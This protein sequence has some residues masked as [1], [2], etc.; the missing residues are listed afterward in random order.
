MINK[1][2]EKT[3]EYQR[4]ISKKDRKS[5]SQFFTTLSIAQYM[6][7]LSKVYKCKESLNILDCGAGTGILT[8]S[9][10]DKLISEEFNGQICIDLY[11]N[12]ENVIEVLKENMKMYT[13]KYDNINI[14]IIQEN[15]ILSN[16][17][18]WQ[19]ENFVGKYDIVISNPPYKKLVKAS[20]ESIIMD[21]V[22]HGQPN[23]YF[24]FMAMSIKLLRENGEMIFITPRSFTSGAYFRAFREYLL[25]NTI[26]T[27]IH[28]FNSRDNLFKGE[29]V[30]QETIITRTVKSRAMNS[31][32]INLTISDNY[33][34]ENLQNRSICCSDL[35]TSCKNKFILLP[36]SKEEVEILKKLC[37]YKDNLLTL[38]F[39]LKTGKVV[40]FR[41]T[42]YLVKSKNGAVP[43]IWPD[44]FVNNKI[45]ALNN[46]SKFRYILSNDNSRSILQEN[47]DYILIKRFTSKEENRRVQLALYDKSN[48]SQFDKIGIENHVNFIEKEKGVMTKE[49]QYGLFCF[50]NSTMVDKYYRMVNGNTQVNSTEFNVIPTPNIDIIINIGK[51]ILNSVNIDTK[52]CDTIIT[53]YM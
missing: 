3:F 25:K 36:S 12:D 15:F 27:N 13:D 40:D 43:L 4:K 14:N 46:E 44:N 8:S 1:I 47:K 11:E 45:I 17:D 23:I 2:E 35:I 18:I 28:I 49:E 34:F 19:D 29:E 41:A 30:L 48:F 52:T 50:F 22:V 6:S 51:D 7:S 38:G 31:Y 39:K 37:K 42:N 32:D 10:I 9:L 16:K 24:L 33:D 20:E 21:L 26:L 5:K 53:K